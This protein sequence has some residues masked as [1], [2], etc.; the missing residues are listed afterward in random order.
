M[1]N[2][3]FSDEIKRLIMESYGL[4]SDELN[5]Y[6][7]VATNENIFNGLN[8]RNLL[9][10]TATLARDNHPDIH[11]Y[12]HISLVLEKIERGE[13][14][15]EVLAI[16]GYAGHG[17]DFIINNIKDEKVSKIAGVR[18]ENE[19]KYSLIVNEYK[20]KPQILKE[21]LHKMVDGY[22]Y[23]IDKLTSDLEGFIDKKYQKKEKQ[24]ENVYKEKIIK[25]IKNEYLNFD[26]KEYIDNEDKSLLEDLK[27]D[28]EN[29]DQDNILDLNYLV[30]SLSQEESE[31]FK[32]L[33]EYILKIINDEW[34]SQYEID[35][36]IVQFEID[37]NLSKF[38]YTIE[39]GEIKIERT[40]E[41]NIENIKKDLDLSNK[42][43]E[44]EYKEILEKIEGLSL[45]EER[46]STEKLVNKIKEEFFEKNKIIYNNEEPCLSGDEVQKSTLVLT[47]EDK[48]LLSQNNIY[49]LFKLFKIPKNIVSTNYLAFKKEL[50]N[51]HLTNVYKEGYGQTKEQYEKEILTAM[52]NHEEIN[53][54]KLR[55]IEKLVVYTTLGEKR[56]QQSK[57]KILTEALKE[58][59]LAR[60]PYNHQ[61][62]AL[63][64]ELSDYS[65]IIMLPFTAGLPETLKELSKSANQ[66]PK[67]AN[68]KPTKTM[69]QN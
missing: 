5:Y 68:Q 16:L 7:D 57:I 51:Y 50:I 60:S 28:F 3:S 22:N 56:K 65:K 31:N 2:L 59:G 64:K 23:N 46:S 47:N 62:E 37:L 67:S 1:N 12:K 18:F 32:D 13:E 35:E 36:D 25:E 33:S 44:R 66:K 9:I 11:V 61:S 4:K 40:K 53:E 29:Y 14:I 34:Y 8:M 17:K 6:K 42:E 19:V 10:K 41:Y 39:D 27:N 30:K 58:Y 54:L 69:K 45:Y 24:E 55:E 38:R 48:E 52:K 49:V 63:P 26:S 20:D 15:N 43:E 21:E